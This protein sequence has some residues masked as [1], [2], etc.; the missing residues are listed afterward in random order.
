MQWWRDAKFG[1]FIHWGLYSVVGKGEWYVFSSQTDYREYEQLT[2]QFTAEKFNADAWAGAAKDAGMKYMVMVTRH[3]DGFAL[4]DSPGSYEHF[5]SLSSAAHR[6][7][8]AEYTKACRAAGLHVGVY[9]SPLDF[10][11]PGFFFPKMYR[12][13]AELLKAQT[14]AQVHELLSNYG[15]IDVFW[16]DGGDDRWLGL[17][18]LE[19]NGTWQT[20]GFETPYKGKPLWEPEKL[21]AGMRA[22]QPKLVINDRS[23]WEGDFFSR[24]GSLGDFDNHKPWEKCSTLSTGWGYHAGH[25]EPRSLASILQELSNTACRDGNLL[26]NVGPRPDGEIEPKQVA[27]LKEIGGWLKNYG[28]CIYGTR[29]GPWL[30]TKEYGATQ[31]SNAIYVHIWSWPADGKL[32]LPQLSQKISGGAGL[33]GDG[34]SVS[35]ADGVATIVRGQTVS[36]TPLTVVKLKLVQ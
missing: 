29:G 5:N 7:F 14:Y 17:G 8:V 2:N 3:H 33:A 25:I 6:D 10:R 15:P 12:A 1:M 9:Y 31:T 21:V 34:V 26:L 20:R 19:W 16:F 18:G 36:S 23:G 35:L 24:E 11:F 4:W 27:R 22:L 30:P 32:V 28:E 13:N